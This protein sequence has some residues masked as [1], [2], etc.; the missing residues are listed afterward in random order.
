MLITYY[1]ITYYY[2]ANY[3]LI[4]VEFYYNYWHAIS[5]NTQNC[6]SYAVHYQRD[7]KRYF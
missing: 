2:Y 5:I 6:D 3:T 1:D 4:P 7:S